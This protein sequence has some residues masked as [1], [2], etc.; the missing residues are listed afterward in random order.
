M[1]APSR[2]SLFSR[3]RP[4]D[5]RAR[6]L[7]MHHFHSRPRT[8]LPVGRV[9]RIRRRRAVVG[10]GRSTRLFVGFIEP[11]RLPRCPYRLSHSLRHAHSS[12]F[13]LNSSSDTQRAAPSP[14]QFTSTEAS[15]PNSAHTQLR[16]A[17]LFLD[18]LQ[19]RSSKVVPYQ[20]FHSATACRSAAAPLLTVGSAT[21]TTISRTSARSVLL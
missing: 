8:R 2:C 1:L 17:P 16:L 18:R 7:S 4:A 11:G 19:C 6:S 9:P 5:S 14:A 20:P 10:S 12:P 3:S 15:F 13:H 21:P